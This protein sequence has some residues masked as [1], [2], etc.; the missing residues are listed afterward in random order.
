MNHL[1]DRESLA[2]RLEAEQKEEDA[3]RAQWALGDYI[4]GSCINCGRERVCVC[5]NGK[6]R[7]EKCNYVPEDRAFCPVPL[8]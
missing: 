4:A 8:G 7:C 2:G 5:P 3:L 1:N 6:H